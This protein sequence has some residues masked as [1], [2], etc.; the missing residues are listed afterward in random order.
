MLFFNLVKEDIYEK[1]RKE[2]VDFY[3]F[4]PVGILI[5]SIAFTCFFIYIAISIQ[6]SQGAGYV[7]L[8]P[9]FVCILSSYSSAKQVASLF[10]SVKFYEDKG[11]LDDVIYEFNNGIQLADDYIRM[12]NRFILG[13]K[14]ATITEYSEISQ[15]YEYVHRTNLVVDKRLLKAKSPAGEE[16]ILC[17]LPA[18]GIAKEEM[19]HIFVVI[20]AKNNKVR[21]GY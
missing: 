15:V 3:L 20:K 18:A 2:R 13:R 8:I 16:F 14:S 10:K 11:M 17:K 21:F 4:P 12:G 9:A 6:I 1:H 5:A 19:L 7:G